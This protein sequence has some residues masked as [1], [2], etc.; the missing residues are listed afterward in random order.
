LG[1]SK[2]EKQ[3]DRVMLKNCVICGCEFHAWHKNK[4]I[5]SDACAAENRLIRRAAEK[6]RYYERY[7]ERKREER[8][9]YYERHPDK[10][11]AKNKK[12]IERIKLN[13]KSIKETVIEMRAALEVIRQMEMQTKQTLENW[14]NEQTV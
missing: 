7:P 6:R 5:C 1:L 8:K 2:A 12:D 3:G 9:R 14:K 13:N 10:K 4:I 11:A